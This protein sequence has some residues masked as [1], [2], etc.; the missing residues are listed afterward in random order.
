V[1]TQL[2]KEKTMIWKATESIQCEWC[3][4]WFVPSIA[5]KK[6]CTD[7]CRGFLWRQNNPRIDIRILKFVM[8]VLAQELNVKMQENKNRFFL[9]GADMAKL[10]HKY[11]ER[12]GE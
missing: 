6:C 8:L 2:T 1:E 11:K 12:K 10:E 7:A 5:K 4:K 9:N 3:G